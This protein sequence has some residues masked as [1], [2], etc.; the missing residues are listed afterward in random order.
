MCYVKQS[1]AKLFCQSRSYHSH[2]LFLFGQSLTWRS[3][4]A[5]CT[6]ELGKDDQY[7]S[8]CQKKF[9]TSHLISL[10]KLRG[11][12]EHDSGRRVGL[13]QEGEVRRGGQ[14]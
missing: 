14:E 7:A 6:T 11:K 13:Y 2:F 9:K 8:F 1:G 4:D 12:N 10:K 3:N 5:T